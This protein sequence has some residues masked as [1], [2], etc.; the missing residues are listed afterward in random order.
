MR[1]WNAANG[2]LERTLRGH[3]QSVYSV[4]YSPDGRRVVSA[5]ADGTVRVWSVDGGRTVILRGHEGPVSSA[6]FDPSGGGW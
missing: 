6:E 1:L 5:G 3:G 2:K 4:S